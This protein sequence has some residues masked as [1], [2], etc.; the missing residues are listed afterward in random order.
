MV[1]TR[2]IT[3]RTRDLLIRTLR[4]E[5]VD[6]ADRGKALEIGEQEVTV[7]TD[8]SADLPLSDPTVSRL[9]FAIRPHDDGWLVR[10]L[11][12]THGTQVDGVAAVEAFVRPAQRMVVGTATLAVSTSGTVVRLPHS[13]SSSWGAALGKSAA[14]RRLFAVLP[15]IAASDVPVLLEGET[16]T[17]KTLLARAIHREGG[18]RDGPFV[19]VDCGAIAPG[20]IE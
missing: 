8:S 7:G 9:H 4:L 5:A 10:D 15:R 12:S 11:G 3:A 18:R 13:G 2:V 16:G 20:L 6:G 19:V 1:R 14:M 17:G